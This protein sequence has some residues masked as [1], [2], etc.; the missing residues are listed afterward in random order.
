MK[1][2][3]VYCVPTYIPSHIYENVI[4]DMWVRMVS[5]S[6]IAAFLNKLCL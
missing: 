5:A 2:N 1:V 4:P 6:Q 3:I